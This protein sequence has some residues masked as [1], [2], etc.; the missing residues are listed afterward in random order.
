MRQ[1]INH[2]TKQECYL[3]RGAV[4]VDANTENVVDVVTDLV[5]KDHSLIHSVTLQRQFVVY[6]GDMNKASCTE[7]LP[8]LDNYQKCKTY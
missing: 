3:L 7:Y 2:F 8:H 6:T 5:V 1:Y 4:F